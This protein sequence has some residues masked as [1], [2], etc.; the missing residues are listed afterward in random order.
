MRLD[1][2]LVENV[3][4]LRRADLALRARIL[5]VAGPNGAGK[6]SLGDAISMALLGKPRRVSLKK[7]FGQLVTEGA[8][9]GRAAVW[10]D[11]EQIGEIKLPSGDHGESLPAGAQYLPYVLDSALFAAASSDERRK[12]LFQLTGCKATPDLIEARLLELGAAAD[13]VATIKPLLLSGFPAACADA[14][15]RATESKGAWRAVTGETW[16]EKK[17]EGWEVEVP[18]GVTFNQQDLDAAQAALT[19]TLGQIEDGNRFLGGLEHQAQQAAGFAQRKA[20]LE[21]RAALLPRA[22]AK[23]QATEK[24]LAE[25]QAE[26]DRL[27]P[28]LAEANANAAGMKCPC[29]EATL[30]VEDGKLVEFKGAKG[31]AKKTSDL[32]FAM[33][34]AKD[35]LATYQRIRANDLVAIQQAEQAQRDL[36]ALLTEDNAPPEPGKVEKTQE[37]LNQLR[38][39]RDQ[40]QAKVNALIELRDAE[41]GAAETNRKAAQH[42]ADVIAWLAIAE[43]LSPE[44]IPAELLNKA[45]TPVNTALQVMSRLTGWSQVALNAG[46]EL[47]ANGRAYGLLSESE[48]WRCDTLIALAI[49]Q[50]SGLRIALLDRFDVL[51]LPARAQLLGAL[52]EMAKLDSIDTVIVSGTLKARPAT[53]ADIQTVWLENGVADDGTTLQKAS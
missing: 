1:R 20:E 11:G 6:S 7:D 43:H 41:A 44:G 37:A 15:T 24:D 45:M 25:W 48:R 50:V 32:A 21:E 8:K 4:G 10:A 46:M 49:A 13:K 2:I 42:H 38:Q 22:N 30:K 33:Q 29:C 14:K 52:I 3:L 39:Q 40:Q 5:L 51:D 9:K 17:G 47:T 18:E 31:E 19:K 53:P 28:V 35:A 12:L 23:L 27:A 16:G 34:T 36:E 26:V